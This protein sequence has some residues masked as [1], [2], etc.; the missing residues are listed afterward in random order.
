MKTHA[1][2]SPAAVASHSHSLSQSSRTGKTGMSTTP[3]SSPRAS[4]SVGQNHPPKLSPLRPDV[5]PPSPNYFGLVVDSAHDSRESSGLGNNWS[6]TSS[7]VKSFAAALPK[8]VESNPEFEAFKRQVDLN[9]GKSFALPTSHYVQPTSN[10]AHVRPRPPRWHTHAS[11]TGSENSFPRALNLPRDRPSSRMDVDQDSLHDSAYVSSD[12]KRNS[13][14][15]LFPL[16][17]PGIPRFESPMPMDPMQTRTTLTRSEDRDPRLSMMEHRPEPP[18]PELSEMTRAVTMPLNLEPGHPSLITAAYLKDLLETEDEESLLLLDIRSSNNYALSRIKGALNLCIPTTL[19]KRATYNTEKL[20]QTFQNGPARDKF[21]AWRGVDRIV[22]YDSRSSDKRDTVAAQNMIKK[23]TNEGYTGETGILRGGFQGFL[24]AFPHLVDSSSTTSTDSDGGGAFPGAM[25]GLAP[26]IGG[27]MLPTSKNPFFSNIRQ[28]MDL[29]DGVGQLDVAWPHG[30][31]PAVLPMWLRDA[32]AQPDHGKRVSDRFLRIEL[33]EKTRMQNA[34]AAFNE[35]NPAHNPAFNGRVQL[36][37]VEKGGKNR[38]KDIL[39]FE[40]ARVKLQNRPEGSCDYVNASHLTASRSN[41]RYIASQGPL[42]DT[43][44][45][46]WSVIW[47]QDV[48]VIVMLTAESEGGQL[49]CHTYWKDREYGPI[50]LKQLSE[51]KA[52]LDLDKNCYPAGQSNNGASSGEANRKR[53]N[54]TTS[55]ETAA[56]NPPSVQSQSETFVTIRKFALTHSAHPFAPIR[57][58]THL[59]FSAWPDFGTPAQP[60]HL[61]AL[62]ELANVMQRASL[63]VETASIVGSSKIAHD[64]API[65]WYDEPEADSASRPM[66]VHCSAGCGRTGAF[67]TV[68]SVIDMLKRQRLARMPGGQQPARDA[69]GDTPMTDSDE[70]ISPMTNREMGFQFNLNQQPRLET[71]GVQGSQSID[72]SWLR[73]ESVDLIQ[74]TVEDFREQRLSMVQSLRQYVLCYETVLEWVHRLHDRG[75]AGTPG[76]RHRSESSQLS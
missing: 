35:G 71:P 54:T 17:L 4:I 52:S 44:E 61:L 62:V 69:G 75:P 2:P 26:V 13:E 59:H 28:N 14:A 8:H 33:E 20:H 58:I 45:D 18:S 21:A 49:K 34:Y 11:D 1:R 64:M 38:Y 43:F 57:E 50:K 42:P 22:V 19:L 73:D 53:A 40:H 6:P 15:S 39:P 7:S 12:S 46:F 76:R 29:A 68:D 74:K 31:E 55:I 37:G 63:P 66:L 36:S 24:T 32:A 60:S 47:E 48:R 51:K 10:P 27:V 23:F 25:G 5:R 16:Q 56:A 41:K 9:R 72:V 65:S 70:A 3:A 30:L 67:C